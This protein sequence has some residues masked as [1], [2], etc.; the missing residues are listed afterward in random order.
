MIIRSRGIVRTKLEPNHVILEKILIILPRIM[1]S[2]TN[3]TT[4]LVTNISLPDTSPYLNGAVPRQ[5][6]ALSSL[7]GVPIIFKN[8]TIM[9]PFATTHLGQAREWN[10]L[11]REWDPDEGEYATTALSKSSAVTLC[12]SGRGAERSGQEFSTQ[13]RP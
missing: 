8:S 7:C 1:S 13:Q 12:S 9:P 3:P 4:A 2:L 5:N 11:E 10:L 6:R